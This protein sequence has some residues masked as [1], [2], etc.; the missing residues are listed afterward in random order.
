M[1]DYKKIV[2]WI[3]WFSKVDNKTDYPARLWVSFDVSPETIE[4]AFE[5]MADCGIDCAFGNG[6]IETL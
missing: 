2:S 5:I 1:I 4:E 3:E 6:W